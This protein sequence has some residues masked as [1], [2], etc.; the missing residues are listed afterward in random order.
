MPARFVRHFSLTLCAVSLLVAWSDSVVYAQLASRTPRAPQERETRSTQT[1]NQNAVM[2][3]EMQESRLN[4]PWNDLTPA[5]QTKIRSVVS[6]TPLF[7]RMPQQTVY[8]DAE[9]YNFLLQ[10]PDL[11]IGFWEYMGAT[12]LSLREIRSNQYILKETGGTVATVEVLYRTN[13]LCIVYA[14]G[15]YRG[16]LLAKAYQGD[17][18]LVLRS[19]F[20]RDEADEPVVVCDLDA[21]VQINSLGADVLAKLF[22]SSLTKI[23]EGNFE[24][25]VGFVSQV[26]QAAVR[27][28][29]VLKST[30][31][32]ITA[33]RPEVYAE[34][35]DVADRTAMRYAKRNKPAP[36][37]IVQHRP[38][39]VEPLK[40]EH[41]NFAVSA[42]VSE[43]LKVP[44][45]WG[46]EHF[47]DS[48][49]ESPL[50]PPAV[51]RRGVSELSVPKPHSSMLSEN[52]VP[53][54]PKQ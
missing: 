15:E 4:L 24:V 54:L 25:T 7:H 33:I 36:L 50:S 44:A 11:V 2:L 47:F 1:V 27:N 53:P 21:F 22:F 17:V 29:S 30:A 40:G 37:S 13:D 32:E 28:S 26:S 39:H 8:A 5:A 16:P 31:E 51:D 20:T 9:M 23:A 12:Q 46:M 6:G 34:F 49:F 48:S 41:Q 38:E 14:R 10:Q 18:V 35:C 45:D 43:A 52:A 19:Y 3:R 42:K